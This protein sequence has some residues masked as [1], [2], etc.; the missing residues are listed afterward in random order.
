MYQLPRGYNGDSS[1]AGGAVMKRSHRSRVLLGLLFA[2]LPAGGPG[3]AQ[4]AGGQ[5]FSDTT[6]VTLVEVPVQVVRDGEPVRGLSAADFTIHEGSKL[7]PI[8]GFD[9]VDLAAPASQALSAPIPS[10]A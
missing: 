4:S 9:V 5:K 8:T 1:L 3:L 7:R 2:L 6:H 10:A